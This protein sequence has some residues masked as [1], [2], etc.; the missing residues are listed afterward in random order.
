MTRPDIFNLRKQ[1][2]TYGANHNN[3]INVAIHMVFVPTI[4]WTGKK[5]L[6]NSLFF[7][8]RSNFSCMKY[9]TCICSKHR[10]TH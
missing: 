10:P 1:L 7:Y 3:P 4:F 9:S 6:N 5:I 8:K 2:V